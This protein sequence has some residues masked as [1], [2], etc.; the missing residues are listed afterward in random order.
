ML[1]N[2]PNNA[3]WKEYKSKKH[4]FVISQFSTAIQELVFSIELRNS[5]QL[6]QLQISFC[7]VLIKI[8]IIKS[9]E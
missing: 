6:I 3:N 7:F 9:H 8:D 1:D 5:K 4:V 2:R